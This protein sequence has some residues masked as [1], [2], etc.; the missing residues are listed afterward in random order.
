VYFGDKCG[1]IFNGKTKRRKRKGSAGAQVHSARQT[2][3]AL[4][5]LDHHTFH[6]AVIGWDMAGD[7]AEAL[8]KSIEEGAARSSLSVPRLPRCA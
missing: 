3:R 6:G 4:R 5:L 2:S 7:T 8:C 1:R